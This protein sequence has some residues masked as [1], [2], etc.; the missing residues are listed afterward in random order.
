[1]TD[2]K[3]IITFIHLAGLALG[4][5]GAWLLDMYIVKNLV[6]KPIT[7]EKYKFIHFS[8]NI[9]TIGLAI[10]WIS[11][12]AFIAFYYFFTPEYLHNQKVWAKVFVVTVLTANGFLIHKVLLPKLKQS[13]GSPMLSAFSYKTSYLMMVVGT[14]SCVSWLYPVILGVTK[15][16]NFTVS[17]YNII[18]FYFVMLIF[19]LI[20]GQL[21]MVVAMDK[22][23]PINIE[24]RIV[25]LKKRFGYN[26]NQIRTIFLKKHKINIPSSIVYKTLYDNGLLETPQKRERL[27]VING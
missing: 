9:V 13:I 6:H 19:G 2:L 11:G 15:S 7:E 22:N 1:M 5:G 10:L 18:G 27:N 25:N 21:L 16:L 23:K 12:I 4:L 14:V 17:A 20:I 8:A 3:S 24:D 26:V